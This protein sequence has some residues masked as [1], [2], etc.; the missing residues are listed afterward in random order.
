MRVLIVGLVGALMLIAGAF[1]VVGGGY[2]SFRYWATRTFSI[3]EG[4]VFLKVDANRALGEEVERRLRWIRRSL[5]WENIRYQSM[6]KPLG[7]HL[8][9]HME[10]GGG[11]IFFTILDPRQFDVVVDLIETQPLWAAEY[12]GRGLFNMYILP[13][14]KVALAEEATR[15]LQNILGATLPE[16]APG[17]SGQDGEEIDLGLWRVGPT[18]L[19]FSRAYLEALGDFRPHRIDYRSDSFTVYL[20]GRDDWSGG[21]AIEP[22]QIRVPDEVPGIGSDPA[23]LE[24]L[25]IDPEIAIS[26]ADIFDASVVKHGHGYNV[27]VRV[28]GLDR[29]RVATSLGEDWS[30]TVIQLAGD[31]IAEFDGGSLARVR[32]YRPNRVVVDSGFTREQAQDFTRALHARL[33]RPYVAEVE[34]CD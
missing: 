10:D 33:P 6:G 3:D 9:R 34:A 16:T 20:V 19:A 32:M 24:Q 13:E 8:G 18:C 17:T 11:R 25:V 5:Y 23:M 4:V 29:Q 27:E 7:R 2:Q 22:G 12:D 21:E 31:S 30:L 26:A 14:A 15:R 28:G 1:Y